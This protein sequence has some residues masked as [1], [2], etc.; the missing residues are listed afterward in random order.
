MEWKGKDVLY[1]LGMVY[2]QQYKLE[3]QVMQEEWFQRYLH[4]ES[5]WKVKFI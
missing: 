3:I 2:K 4:E 1:D 5:K